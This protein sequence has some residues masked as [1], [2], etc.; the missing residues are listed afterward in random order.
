MQLSL[1]VHEIISL[2]MAMACD[3]KL[4]NFTANQI[5]FLFLECTSDKIEN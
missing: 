1:S 3:I 5:L 2:F 4:P